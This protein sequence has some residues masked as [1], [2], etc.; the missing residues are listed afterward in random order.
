MSLSRPH[1]WEYAYC[2]ANCFELSAIQKSLRWQ[3]WLSHSEQHCA[4][5][6]LRHSEASKV[7]DVQV[8]VVAPTFEDSHD[9]LYVGPILCCQQF[10]SILGDDS[11]RLK[12]RGDICKIQEKIIS[13]VV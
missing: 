3:E 10:W 8:H 9:L 13:K 2:L 4:K 11:V 5:S 1:W 6:L 7:V 12:R